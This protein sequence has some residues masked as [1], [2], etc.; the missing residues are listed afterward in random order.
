[1]NRYCFNYY[2]LFDFVLGLFTAVHNRSILLLDAT[3]L[4]YSLAK[5]LK[6]VAMVFKL[7]LF[8]YHVGPQLVHEST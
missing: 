3:L 4:R 2:V 5:N 7:V 1:M 8:A 6:H